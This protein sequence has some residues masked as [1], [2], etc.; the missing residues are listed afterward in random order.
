MRL[1]RIKGVDIVV[2]PVLIVLAMAAAF[3][4]F[5]IRVLILAVAVLFHEAAHWVTAAFLG[6]RLE[7]IRL[8]PLGGSV[9]IAG[10]SGLEPVRESLIALAG[11]VVSIMLAVLCLEFKALGIVPAGMQIFIAANTVISFNLL[12]FHGWGQSA[13]E[14]LLQTWHG[15]CH[16][17]VYILGSIIAL[18]RLFTVSGAG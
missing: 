8:F 13:K 17:G 4:G 14:R 2:S 12:P 3:S 6:Y 5:P 16:Q 10:M 15:G 18:I 7:E 11:P 9:R 1:A